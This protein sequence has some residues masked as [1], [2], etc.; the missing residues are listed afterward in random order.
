MDL[1]TLPIEDRWRALE[2]LI[3]EVRAL[4]GENSRLAHQVAQNALEIA[5]LQA[6]L[7]EGLPDGWPRAIRE[8]AGPKSYES[9]AD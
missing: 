6:W 3:A 1:L 8:A 2:L 7:G 4:R 5:R 9:G